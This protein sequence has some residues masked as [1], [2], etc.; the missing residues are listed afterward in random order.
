MQGAFWFPGFYV[1]PDGQ[2]GTQTK[3]EYIK[4]FTSVGYCGNTAATKK[5]YIVPLVDITGKGWVQSDGEIS[6]NNAQSDDTSII[7]QS[8]VTVDCGI[9]DTVINRFPGIFGNYAAGRVKDQPLYLGC[10]S[11]NEHTVTEWMDIDSY[12]RVYQFMKDFIAELCK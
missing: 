11:G 8:T 3:T 7:V 2:G 12:A 9:I 1:L 5:A 4:R 6:L 10:T